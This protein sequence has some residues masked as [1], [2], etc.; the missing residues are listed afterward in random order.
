RSEGALQ[1]IR[2]KTAVHP[3]GQKDTLHRTKL[4]GPEDC[5]QRPS[6]LIAEGVSG[7]EPVLEG[8][9]FRVREHDGTVEA[10]EGVLAL[11]L[12]LVH[13]SMMS[14]GKWLRVAPR[15]A[16]QDDPW[17]ERV[18]RSQIAPLANRP[19]D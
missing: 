8:L 5:F 7:N 12:K 10:Q 18:I 2:Y 4:V 11:E 3:A 15:V 14:G 6:G 17:V 13:Q 1:A 16:G 19:R 9:G